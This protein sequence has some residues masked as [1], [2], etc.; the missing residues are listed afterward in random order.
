MEEAVGAGRDSLITINAA[1][2]D[3]AD[4]RLVR[5]HVVGLIAG[6]VGAEQ[7]VLGD[8]VGVLRDEEGVLHIA[9]RVVGG[10]VEHREHVLV[11]VNLWTMEKS[12]A[13]ALE[14]FDN[15]VLHDGQRMARA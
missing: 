13:H 14:D 1:R 15:L 7:H 5:L 12:E 3:D 2:A 9:G 10:E 8:V 4:G 6:G 11:V